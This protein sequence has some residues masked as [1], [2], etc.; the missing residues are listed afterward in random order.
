MTEKPPRIVHAPFATGRPIEA[1]EALIDD[2]DLWRD[3]NPDGVRCV[4]PLSED[5]F[6]YVLRLQEAA[7]DL[8][9]AVIQSEQQYAWHDR[10]HPPTPPHRFVDP[11][12]PRLEVLDNMPEVTTKVPSDLIR[13]LYAALS[14][15]DT[16]LAPKT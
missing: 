16:E 10:H 4:Y 9:E 11:N 3:D 2:D 12:R 8:C 14:Q 7:R 6:F 15:L 13:K 1:A 5:Q